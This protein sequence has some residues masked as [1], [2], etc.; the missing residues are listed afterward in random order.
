ML[1]DL[2]DDLSAWRRRERARR[3]MARLDPRLRADIG[4]PETD[5]ARAWTPDRERLDRRF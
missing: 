5:G 1:R 3:E 4:L 2:F